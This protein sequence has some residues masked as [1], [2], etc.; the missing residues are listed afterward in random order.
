MVYVVVD[1]VSEAFTKGRACLRRD[2]RGH[3]EEKAIDFKY[4]HEVE[5]LVG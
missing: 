1:E 2:P 5:G 3:L 4:D